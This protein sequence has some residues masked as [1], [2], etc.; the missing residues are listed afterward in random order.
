MKRWIIGG[1]ILFTCAIVLLAAMFMRH[2]QAERE[3]SRRREATYSLALR[4]YS[5][6]V[7]PGMSRNDV[8]SYLRQNGIEFGRICCVD[9]SDTYADTVLI[10]K[11]PPPAWC[12]GANVY[13]AFQFTGASASNDPKDKLHRISIFKLP[14]DCL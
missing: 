3:A 14:V 8:E 11:D 2:S 10:G 1:A 13:I 5:E 9:R 4:H 12:S 7:A 6:A